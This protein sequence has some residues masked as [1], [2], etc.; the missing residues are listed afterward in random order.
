VN[1][2]APINSGTYQ[3]NF[4]LRSPDG[5][6]FGTGNIGQQTFWVRIVVLQPPATTPIPT[7]PPSCGTLPTRVAIGMTIQV[8]TE[9]IGIRPQP[10]LNTH[11]MFELLAGDTMTV[12]NGPS[13]S[14]NSY[15]WYITSE[16]GNGWV[17]EGNNI[18]YFVEPV[19]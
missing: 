18:I 7:I 11:K 19:P 3:G 6:M 2:Y 17:R 12:L 14:D 13:C 16:L 15:F 8:L 1:L 9:S 10:N 4:K 5:A